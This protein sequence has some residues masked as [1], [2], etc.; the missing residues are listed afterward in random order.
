L[1]G[2]VV[3]D[4]VLDAP[5]YKVELRD[6][7]VNLD[8][9]RVW[10]LVLK[11]FGSAKRVKQLFTVAI[12]TRLVRAVDQERFAVVGLVRQV[13]LLGVVRDEPLEVS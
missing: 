1:V 13:L 7:R 11:L 12:E 9:V 6:S 5:L 2:D 10:N 8:S 3:Y 4:V